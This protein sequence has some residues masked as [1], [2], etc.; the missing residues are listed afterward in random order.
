MLNNGPLHCSCAHTPLWSSYY[1][2]FPSPLIDPT[3]STLVSSSS[4][5]QLR[6][7][8]KRRRQPPPTQS[9]QPC[10]RT[11]LS[12]GWR[13]VF[14]CGVWLGLRTAA[15]MTTPQPVHRSV[16][17]KKAPSV[18]LLQHETFLREGTDRWSGRRRWR[19]IDRGR[20]DALTRRVVPTGRVGAAAGALVDPRHGRRVL[21]RARLI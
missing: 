14:A 21:P 9:R 12:E 2:P 15:T 8:T 6:L 18:I 4:G 20:A 1:L 5:L 7:T 13:L 17:V 16:L 10:T 11:N 3:L 19:N